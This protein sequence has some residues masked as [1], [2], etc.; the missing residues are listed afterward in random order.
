MTRRKVLIA[1]GLSALSFCIN[2]L[3]QQPPA[4]TWRIGFMSAMPR[5]ADGLPPAPLRKA[6]A[7][8]GY[9]DGKNVIY[10]GRWAEGKTAIM[11][12]LAQ[13]LVNEHVDVIVA[14]G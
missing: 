4:K 2:S 9:A 1:A 7:A 13:E 3:A 12:T 11:P 5:P 6:L 8:L 10:A 14:T